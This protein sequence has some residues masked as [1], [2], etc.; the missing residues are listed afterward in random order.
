M[1]KRLE[2]ELRKVFCQIKRVF[3]SCTNISKMNKMTGTHGF[4]IGY[5][6]KHKDKDIFQRDLEKRFSVRRS[7]MSEILKLM[8]TNGLIERVSVGYDARLKKII[9]TEKAR[10]ELANIEKEFS[11]Y[12]KEFVK[13]ISEEEMKAFYLTLDKI[14][15]NA[16]SIAKHKNIKPLI[17]D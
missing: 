14:M 15:V 1:E 11:F 5:L 17:E 6:S 13:G 12:E 4:I 2:I 3:D 8:E 16:E 10:E 7:T 9:L